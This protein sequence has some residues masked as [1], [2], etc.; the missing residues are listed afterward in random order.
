MNSSDHNL[1]THNRLVELMLHKGDFSTD[2][3]HRMT[4]LLPLEQMGLLVSTCHELNNADLTLYT[5]PSKWNDGS[6]VL[7][8]LSATFRRNK[9]QVGFYLLEL[10][11]WI[12]GLCF[13]VYVDMDYGKDFNRDFVL[14]GIYLVMSISVVIIVKLCVATETSVTRWIERINTSTVTEIMLQQTRMSLHM[15]TNDT[16]PLLTSINLSQCP[17]SST[18]GLIALI[19]RCPQ[20]TSLNLQGSSFGSKV[21]LAISKGCPR[22]INLN[23]SDIF[24]SIADPFVIALSNGCP[25]LSSLNLGCTSSEYGNY[26]ITDKSV[27]AL[28]NGCPQLTCLSLYGC[29]RITDA[30]VVALSNGC[31]QLNTLNLCYCTEITDA[32]VRALSN[33]CPQLTTL[34]V[35][36]LPTDASVNALVN[37]C[38]QLKELD[39]RDCDN[40][41]DTSVGVLCQSHPQL[42]FRV[43]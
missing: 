22:L 28:S 20:L 8:V 38:S 41:T 15:I 11:V 33:G 10:F 35:S 25:L 39:L 43:I 17:Y 26:A 27:I 2:V 12:V 9:Y 24:H 40:I 23:L 16:F 6:D 18:K 3:V 7:K 31:P 13:L 5:P 37:G 32:S 4:T 14:T 34:V 1:N 19:E 42:N 29:T 30:S 36:F 21:A